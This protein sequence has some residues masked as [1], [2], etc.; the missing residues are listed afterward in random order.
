MDATILFDD[1]QQSTPNADVRSDELWISEAELEAATGWHLAP[2]GLCQGEAC[3][4][5]PP[6]ANWVGDGRVNLSAFAAHR[7]QGTARDASTGLWSFGPPAESLFE[8]GMA[9]D[10][11]LP[12][13]SGELHSLADYRGRKVLLMTW[14]S[15]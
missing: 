8:D 13:F 6:E 11:V 5:I 7:G 1:H 3:V 2:K 4:P 14:A 9:P 15:W 12:D 10:F